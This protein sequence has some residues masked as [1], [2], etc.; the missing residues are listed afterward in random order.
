MSI[1]PRKAAILGCLRFKGLKARKGTA[2]TAQASIAVPGKGTAALERTGSEKVG[3]GVQG[4]GSIGMDCTR[5][6]SMGKVRQ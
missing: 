3:K 6:H 2:Q 5:K 4:K 1:G